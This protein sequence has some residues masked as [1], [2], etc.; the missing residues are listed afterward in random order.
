MQ[1]KQSKYHYVQPIYIIDVQYQPKLEQ[2]YDLIIKQRSSP[3]R[4][5]RKTNTGRQIIA[6]I[7]RHL[8]LHPQNID[9]LIEQTPDYRISID[10]GQASLDWRQYPNVKDSN[11]IKII[12]DPMVQLGWLEKTKGHHGKKMADMFYAPEGSPLRVNWSYTKLDYLPPKVVIKLYKKRNE[13]DGGYRSPDIGKMRLPKYKKALEKH[14]IPQMKQLSELMNT[15]TYNLPFED[16]QLRRGFV[17]GLETCGGRLQANYQLMTEEERLHKILIDGQ[18]VTEI[19]VVSCGMV[20][21]HSLAKQPV[22][23][24]DDLYSLVDTSLTR[25]E[26]KLIITA[27]CNSKKHVT[28]RNWTTKFKQDKKLGPIVAKTNYKQFCK[29]LLAAFPWL[30]KFLIET[31][32][33]SL[34]TQWLE[35]EAVIKSMFTVLGSGYGC[36]SVHESLIVPK[37]AESIAQIAMV[38]AFEEVAG[39]TPKLKVK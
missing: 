14:F 29:N 33:L 17:G 30:D 12:I 36:L 4:H 7:T 24:V 23:D 34:K 35:S 18:E 9:V 28:S 5:F 32:D 8:N 1:R 2:L 11:S 38:D 22:P 21:L 10:Q 37:Q 20:L 19:D 25:K 15:H 6:S 31:K 16:Y 27:I 26:L 13:E 3:K 39:V